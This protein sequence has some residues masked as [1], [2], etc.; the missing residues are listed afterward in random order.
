M[1]DATMSR[2]ST[3]LSRAKRLEQMALWLGL[4]L[5]LLL[6]ALTAG[7]VNYAPVSQRTAAYEQRLAPIETK[8]SD[9]A[10]PMPTIPFRRDRLV[11]LE[12]ADPASESIELD[13]P[14]E[15]S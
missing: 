4:P 14:S 3:G 8:A 9:E 2:R 5:L 13:G 12:T 11:P 6:L 1:M 10:S 15:I 7:I